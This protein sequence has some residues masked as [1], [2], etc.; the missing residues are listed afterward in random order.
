MT[1]SSSTRRRFLLGAVGALA[2]GGA[3]YVYWRGVRYP[4]LHFAGAGPA[5]TA[6]AAGGVEVSAR[7]A[8]VLEAGPDG[9]RF[10]AFTPEPAFTTRG[11][12]EVRIVVEN[13]HRDAALEA[14]PAQAV[15]EDRFGL[16]R[17]L[18]LSAT[19]ET[20]FSWRFPEADRYRF[21]VIGDSGG[22]TELE[23]VLR[24]GGE[25]GAAF[26]L[27]LG[28]IYYEAGDF[29]RAAV[30]LNAAAIPTY[31][32]IGNHDFHKGWRALYPRFNSVVGPSNS[33]FTLGG[34][35][36][37]NFDTAADFIPAARGQRAR[38]LES[39]RPVGAGSAVRDR[40]A[41][42]HAPLRDPDP[43]RDHAVSRVSEARWLREKLLAS[44]SRNLLVGHIHIKE[45]FDDQGLHTFISGQGLGHA[46]LIGDRPYRSFAEILLGD[47]EPG[48]PVRYQWQPLDMPLEAHCN[49]RNLGVFDVLQRPDVKARLLEECGRS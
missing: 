18:T 1:T 47:V 4:L 24:R 12:G 19:T 34:V 31:G 14:T 40:V 27:H 35:E 42:T 21:A 38:I 16:S 30:N 26:L 20:R 36:F 2:A 28:D 11:R 48:E 10:R 23:W 32:A 13:L 7:G 3:A 15:T 46:D 41:F 22:G 37:V 49:A 33:R 45:E 17:S 25:L 5:T 43:A 39:L 44:G 6:E 9:M 29:E 8:A